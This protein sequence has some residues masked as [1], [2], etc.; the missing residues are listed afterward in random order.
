MEDSKG[1]E[2]LADSQVAFIFWGNQ[3]VFILAG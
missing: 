1:P 2:K 3:C